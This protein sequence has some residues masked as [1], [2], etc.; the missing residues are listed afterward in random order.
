MLGNA[1]E[2]VTPQVDDQPAGAVLVKGAG[3]GD[4]PDQAA[5]YLHRVLEA[6]VRHPSTGFR[7]VRE[8]RG[9]GEPR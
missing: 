2:M 5:I 3:V 9:A 1:R 8:I 6:G 7:C 4:D